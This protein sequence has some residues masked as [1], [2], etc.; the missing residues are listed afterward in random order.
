MVL[1]VN[2]EALLFMIKLKFIVPSLLLIGSIVLVFFIFIYD[3]L[4]P[5][6]EA[7]QKGVEAVEEKLTLTRDLTFASVNLTKIENT[8]YVKLNYHGYMPNITENAELDMDNYVYFEN[9]ALF[10]I[11]D[12]FDDLS[13]NIYVEDSVNSSYIQDIWNLLTECDADLCDIFEQDDL[14]A[15]IE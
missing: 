12:N 6:E 3:N 8:Y 10:T 15:F 11:E 9:S 14:Y 5:H 7:I 13:R 2:E 1:N 4:E